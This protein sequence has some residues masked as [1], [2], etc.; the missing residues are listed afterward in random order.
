[1]I[2]SSKNIRPGDILRKKRFGGELTET[3]IRAQVGDPRVGEDTS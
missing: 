2:D 1:M 3:E